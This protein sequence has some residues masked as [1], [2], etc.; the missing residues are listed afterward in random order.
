MTDH[1]IPDL[2]FS[3]IKC[4]ASSRLSFGLNSTRGSKETTA[5]GETQ[6]TYKAK[7]FLVRIDSKR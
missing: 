2:Y 5:I 4:G 6:P 1:V 7:K 3:H